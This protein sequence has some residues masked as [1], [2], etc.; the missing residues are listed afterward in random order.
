MFMRLRFFLAFFC[1]L[2]SYLIGLD[3]TLHHNFHFV[4]NSTLAGSDRGCK[5]Y[6]SYYVTPHVQFSMCMGQSDQDL[7]NGMSIINLIRSR[8]YLPTCRVMHL[9]LWM[10]SQ[11]H[12]RSHIPRD[13]FVDVGSN[14]GISLYLK[15]LSSL[16][17]FIP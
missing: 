7:K 2:L 9:M 16:S 4:T 1:S 14:I 12:D 8:G 13:S 11:V 15:C 6:S 5:H 10:Y 17:V 3:H